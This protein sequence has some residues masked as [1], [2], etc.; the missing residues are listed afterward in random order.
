ME[1]LDRAGKSTLCAKLAKLFD[2]EL[3]HFPR[4]RIVG[5]KSPQDYQDQCF[6]DFQDA[7][8]WIK[9]T[10][11]LGKSIVLDRYFYSYIAYSRAQGLVPKDINELRKPDVLLL[12]D[13]PA[14]ITRTRK[15]FGLDP[16][17]KTELQRKVRREYAR[18]MRK[19]SNCFRIENYDLEEI[20]TNC[21]PISL[22]N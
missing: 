2:A 22:L 15:D 18:A 11:A 19:N 16:L 3:V 20:N 9:T 14:T 21:S 7:Q 6:A 4:N 10:L 5:A 1:G 13:V 17:E 12:V 8:V